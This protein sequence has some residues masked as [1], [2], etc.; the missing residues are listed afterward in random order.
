[1]SASLLNAAETATPLPSGRSVIVRVH[2]GA[3]ELEV[4]SPAGAVE[5]R[6]TL[7]EDGPVI[8][9]SAARL[10]LAAAD[11]VAVRCRRFDVRAEAG[12]RLSGQEMHVQ[13]EDDIH[14]NGKVIRLNC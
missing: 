2:G 5:V 7:G 6:I 8:H 4:R 11:I 1:M 12:L 14:L 13:T 3:E 9:L 10:E